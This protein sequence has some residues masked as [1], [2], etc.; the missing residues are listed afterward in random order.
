[1]NYEFCWTRG[2]YTDE[3]TD[4][5]INSELCHSGYLPHIDFPITNIL[6]TVDEVIIS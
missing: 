5:R 2:F 4:M 3:Q 1:M 6:V